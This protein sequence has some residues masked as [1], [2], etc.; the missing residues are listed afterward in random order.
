MS[1]KNNL[2]VLAGRIANLRWRLEKLREQGFCERDIAPI[3]YKLIELLHDHQ[4]EEYFLY[5][6]KELITDYYEEN[7]AKS[8]GHFIFLS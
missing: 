7:G 3:R 5:R 1:Q 6:E 4:R 2:R 8:W